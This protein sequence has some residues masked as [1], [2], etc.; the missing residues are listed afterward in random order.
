VTSEKDAALLLSFQ[1]VSSTDKNVTYLYE[2]RYD[3]GFAPNIRGLMGAHIRY[4]VYQKPPGNESDSNS[5]F[6][7]FGLHKSISDVYV[8]RAGTNKK[9]DK[10]FM[11]GY[12]YSL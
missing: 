9:G 12:F 3:I 11:K 10:H 7:I 8:V 6:T 1:N 2:Y 5:K 4:A